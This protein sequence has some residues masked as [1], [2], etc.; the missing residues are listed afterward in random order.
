MESSKSTSSA[1]SY[2]LV[3]SNSSHRRVEPQISKAIRFLA[4]SYRTN[5]SGPDPEGV[6]GIDYPVRVTPL[7]I[8]G[9][10]PNIISIDEE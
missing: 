4:R 10:D 6:E 9:P 7:Q 8:V 1:E 2:C 3:E 5:G